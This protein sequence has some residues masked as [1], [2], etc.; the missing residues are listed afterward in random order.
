MRKKLISVMITT[1]LCAS[2]TAC[3]GANA[4]SSKAPSSEASLSEVSPSEDSSKASSE[5]L[6]PEDSSR[7]SSEA[8]PS[9]DSSKA[10][11]EASSSETSSENAEE[12]TSAKDL[13]EDE[14]LITD[15]EIRS[16]YFTIKLYKNN[17]FTMSDASIDA[18]PDDEE[19]SEAIN[20]ILAQYRAAQAKDLDAYIRSFQFQ[21]LAGPTA[22]LLR[23]MS[24][25]E[26]DDAFRNHLKETGQGTKY[27]LIDDVTALLSDLVEDKYMEE[28]EELLSGESSKSLED[29]T[30]FLAQVYS[31]ISADSQKVADQIEYSAIYDS[32]NG[33]T[34][35]EGITDDAIYLFFIEHCSREENTARKSLYAYCDFYVITDKM[36]YTLPD[37]MLWN[38]NGT[39]GAYLGDELRDS[40]VSEEIRGKSAAELFEM[41]KGTL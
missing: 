2:L 15:N 25:Y 5:A 38:V 7:A 39:C 28:Y 6:P 1:I 41:L 40:Q 34:P 27:E 21:E 3:D 12:S 4:A 14:V 11:S 13:G 23:D 26:D 10:S 32:E 35:L 18:E 29:A 31:E 33:V 19:L 8:L 36:E 37:V 22:E 20:A 17:V 16:K 9:E 30:A 24:V